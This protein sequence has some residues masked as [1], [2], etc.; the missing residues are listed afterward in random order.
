[1]VMGE[2][3]DKPGE[4]AI[5]L[6]ARARFRSLSVLWPR[7]GVPNPEC[8]DVTAHGRTEDEDAARSEAD[9]HSDSDGDWM[10]VRSRKTER[11]EVSSSIKNDMPK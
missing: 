10:V 7:E 5:L 4:L 9:R 11:G 2:A 1:M 3:V 8:R 6:P